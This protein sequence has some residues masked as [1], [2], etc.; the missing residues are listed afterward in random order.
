MNTGHYIADAIKSFADFNTL[1]PVIPKGKKNRYF[2]SL[3]TLGKDTE[4]KDRD[5][6][7]STLGHFEKMIADNNISRNNHIVLEH[8]VL[9]KQLHAYYDRI[10]RKQQEVPKERTR[11]KH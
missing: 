1:F 5:K 4:F 6:V 11:T 8:R 9:L 2:R 7:V 10:V 3:K